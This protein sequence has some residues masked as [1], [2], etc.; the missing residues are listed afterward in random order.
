MEETFRRSSMEGLMVKEETRVESDGE[1]V[2]TNNTGKVSGNKRKAHDDDSTWNPPSSDQKNLGTIKQLESAKTKMGEVREENERLKTL[3]SHILKQYQSL[4]KDFSNTVQ[5]NQDKKSTLTITSTDQDQ[6]QEA[7]EFFSLSLGRSSSAFKIEEKY[8]NIGKL[9]KNDDLQEG[10]ALGL[11]CKFEVPNSYQTSKNTS[12]ENR[13]I[14]PKEVEIREQWPLSKIIKTMRS[15]GDE[16]PEQTHP[17]KARVSV[18]ARCDAPTMN[19]GCQWR[20]YGQKISKGNPCPRAYFRC[21]VGPTCPVRKQ[22]QRCSEDMSILI[23]TY[24]G[25]HNHPLPMSATA[26]AS[27]T[28]AAACMLLSGSTSS[29]PLGTSTTNTCANLHSLNLSFPDNYKS[30]QIYLPNSSFS[31]HPT[32]TLDLT[33]P[34]SSSSLYTPYQINRFPPTSLNFSSLE[35]STT[36]A[37]WSNGYSECGTQSYYKNP[38]VGGKNKEY[39]PYMAENNPSPPQQPLSTET[40]AA[41]TKAITSDPSFRTALEAAISS[42]VGSGV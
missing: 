20:K 24:E 27:S 19:D 4:Q 31:S 25:T 41:A 22:V 3:L 30:R 32:I 38:M 2:G 33:A 13:S 7:H 12:L 15:E 37:S 36:P 26:M 28:S 14:V 35:S 8:S 39:I 6:I 5:Q 17:K 10:L 40:I 23:T 21:T 1:D 42:V 11:D 29:H 18:R 16:V 34:S 9:K